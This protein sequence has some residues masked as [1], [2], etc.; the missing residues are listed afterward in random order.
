M[1][2]SNDSTTIPNTNGSHFFI[3]T[4]TQAQSLPLDYTLSVGDPARERP[5]S[6]TMDRPVECPEIS[7]N[8]EDDD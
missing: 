6:I 3:V 1:A 5:Q 2:N 8:V 7:P 4:G